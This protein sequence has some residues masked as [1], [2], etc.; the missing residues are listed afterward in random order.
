MRGKYSICLLSTTS[1][2]R[3]NSLNFLLNLFRSKPF[4][5]LDL[6]IYSLCFGVAVT[7]SYA[8]FSIPIFST[9]LRIT[10]FKNLSGSF[11]IKRTQAWF[12]VELMEALYSR[13]VARTLGNVL[14]WAFFKTCLKWLSWPPSLQTLMAICSHVSWQRCRNKSS[15]P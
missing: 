11:S 2:K 1:S 3:L 8:I 4:I 7:V 9:I 10:S 13:T 6:F 15:E 5:L 14:G 12:R